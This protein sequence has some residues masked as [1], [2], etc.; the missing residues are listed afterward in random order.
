M[1]VIKFNKKYYKIVN[2]IY[3]KS[4]PKEERYISLNKMIKTKDTELYCLVDKEE[5]TSKVHYAIT[6]L[7]F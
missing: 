6:L 3:K 2:S 5:I 7:M 1:K 4:F